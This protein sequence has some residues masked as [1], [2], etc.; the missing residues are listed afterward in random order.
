MKLIALG[1]NT[2]DLYLNTGE[3]FPGGNAVNVAVHAAEAG[4]DSEY[5]GSFAD[6]VWGKIML[7]QLTQRGVSTAHCPILPGT[8]TKSCTFN[9]I[10][11][12]RHF[13]DVVT[14][15]TWAGPIQL[16]PAQLAELDTADIVV[17]SCN[18]K[19][20]EQLAAVEALSP[21]FAYDFGEKEKYRTDEYYDQVCHGIDLA[22]FSVPSMTDESFRAF[23]EPLHRRGVV[24]VLATMGADGQIL[25]NGSE[26]LR[27]R[28][29]M[30]KATDTMGAGDS[31]LA[32]FL[33]SLFDAGWQKGQ[34]MDREPLL[35]ALKAGQKRSAAN[36]MRPG[37]FGCKIMF[38]VQNTMEAGI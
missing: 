25:S 11:G 3:A 10:D 27:S 8:T 31:F 33:C 26:I 34:P 30:V 28:G 2:V 38:D 37:G 15:P 4:A 22:Q 35:N 32:A 14:G 24:H 13:L 1:D 12:E 17:S 23:C 36:C 7:E 29:E 18:A 21:I 20:P 9:I 6:D 19:L 5:L 16:T